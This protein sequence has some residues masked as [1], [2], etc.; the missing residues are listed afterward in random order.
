MGQARTGAGIAV[1]ALASLAAVGCSGGTEPDGLEERADHLVAAHGD[2][3]VLLTQNVVPE[4][5]MDALFE[6][7][8][9]PDA[10]GCL[11]LDVESDYGVT[12]VWPRGYELRTLD[13]AL[14][15]VDGDGEAVGPIGGFF[16]LGGGEAPELT[17]AMGFTAADRELAHATCPGRYWIVAGTE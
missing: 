5:V 9:A 10:S 17:E 7:R 6:G 16:A 13:G 3:V 1:V 12:A 4:V 2:G 11:R 8:V 15:V 14:H